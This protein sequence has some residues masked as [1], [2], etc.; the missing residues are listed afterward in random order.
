MSPKFYEHFLIIVQN[1]NL[2]Y[3]HTSILPGFF[4]F[5][6]GGGGEAGGFQVFSGFP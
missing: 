4:F 3:W 2:K 6:G 5:G 1:V